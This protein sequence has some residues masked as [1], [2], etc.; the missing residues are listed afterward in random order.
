MPDLASPPYL[1]AIPAPKAFR[2]AMRGFVGACSLITTGADDMA[3]GLVVTSG[4]SLTAE[5]PMILAC[6]NRSA[7]SWPILKQTG[8]FGWSALGSAHQPVAERF[9]GVGGLK[10]QDR[11][12]GA[13]W[14]TGA[15][16]ARHLADA[17]LAFDCTV[18]EMIDRGTHSILIGRVQSILTNPDR[19]SLLYWNGAYHPLPSSVV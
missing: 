17:P 18:E 13:Q 9:S 16:G 4:V 19:G 1:G 10:G 2:D 11:Y 8:V 3:T 12:Q 15:T 6:I 14:M 5:P 7:S